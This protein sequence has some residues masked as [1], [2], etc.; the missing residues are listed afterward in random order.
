[1][2]TFSDDP[3]ERA[4]EEEC[5]ADIEEYG[6]HVLKVH[7]DSDWPD[8]TYSVGLFEKYGIPEIIIL[9]LKPDLAH[10]VITDLAERGRHGESF[11][12]GDSVSGLLEGFDT[13]LRPINPE[14]VQ[15]HFGWAMWF[16]E[17]RP[18]PVAQLVFPT[19]SG[20]WPWDAAA[21]ESFKHD[22]PLLDRVAVPA[23]ALRSS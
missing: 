20:V 1:M 23:W 17:D 21:S 8:F 12:I 6:V 22:Q 15:P 13:A 16:Y 7:G 3:K 14:L 10:R 19:T 2:P 9:G 5:V 18:F 4:A 11:S